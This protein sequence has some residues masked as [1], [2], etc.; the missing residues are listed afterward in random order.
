MIEISTRQMAAVFRVWRL[1]LDRCYVT[2]EPL[3][4]L[5][6]GQGA[7]VDDRWRSSLDALAQGMTSVET[8][9]M[10][11]LS[12]SAVRNVANRAGQAIQRAPK[13]QPT[14]LTFEREAELLA[15]YTRTGDSQF[16]MAKRYGVSPRTVQNIVKRHRQAS[17]LG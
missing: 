5:L 13:I 15:E 1:L 16:T 17:E 4:P 7:T 9:R 6:G 11:G 12:P 2:D 8:G 14:K 10:Y 3:Y